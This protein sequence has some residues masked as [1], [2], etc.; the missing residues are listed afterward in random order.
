MLL[1]VSVLLLSL[2]CSITGIGATAYT[3][4]AFI[5]AYTTMKKV[6]NLGG[7]FSRMLEGGKR[8]VFIVLENLA[9]DCHDGELCSRDY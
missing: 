3:A 6:R 5:G 8:S 9:L 1:P 7:N 2:S 4:C